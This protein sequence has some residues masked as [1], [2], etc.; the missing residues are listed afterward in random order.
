MSSIKHLKVKERLIL[1]LRIKSLNKE[2]NLYL[3]Y[4]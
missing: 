1:V 2:V 4:Y 3:Y